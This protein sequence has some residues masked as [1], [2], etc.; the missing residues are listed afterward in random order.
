M[1]NK[2][3]HEVKH[4]N[5]VNDVSA[6]T[7]RRMDF[8]I[9]RIYLQE[10]IENFDKPVGLISTMMFSAKIADFDDFKVLRIVNLP[11]LLDYYLRIRAITLNQYDTFIAQLNS[12]DRENWYLAFVTIDQFINNINKRYGRKR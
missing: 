5:K 4:Q 8:T 2:Y 11:K 10:A 7:Q 12:S 1:K 9:T 6:R 3:I